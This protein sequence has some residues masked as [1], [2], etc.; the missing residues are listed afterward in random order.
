MTDHSIESRNGMFYNKISILLS[1][2][3]QRVRSDGTAVD[4]FFS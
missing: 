3:L 4:T 1:F 2:I